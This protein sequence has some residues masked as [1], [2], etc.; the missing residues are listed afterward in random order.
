M[1]ATLTDALF[2]LDAQDWRGRH[3]EWLSL[4]NA[5]KFEGIAEDDWVE[6]SLGDPMYRADERVIRRKWK[7]LTPA[8]GGALWAALKA[9]GIKVDRGSSAKPSLND[10]VPLHPT[11]GAGLR[12]SFHEPTRHLNN[13]LSSL[14]DWLNADL[15]EQG[16]FKVA[17]IFAGIIAEGLLEPSIAVKLLEANCWQLCKQMGADQFR[18]TIARAFR[19]VE[20][21]ILKESE[22][23]KQEK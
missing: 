10:A 4:A 3:D 21:K 14:Y 9:A 18:V 1:V 6:W 5:C 8:H 17:C 11:S 12:H 19:H 22:T 2:A 13:R 16:L 23:T 15:T 7:S 20:E